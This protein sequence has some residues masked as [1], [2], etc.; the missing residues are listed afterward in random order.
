[1]R[2]PHPAE[3]YF[4]NLKLAVCVLPSMNFSV[5]VRQLF[6]HALSVFHT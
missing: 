3:G 4:L 1:L 5:S 6:A 2:I